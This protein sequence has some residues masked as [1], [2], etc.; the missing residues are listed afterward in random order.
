MNFTYYLN[1]LK[2]T[3]EAYCKVKNILQLHKKKFKEQDDVDS[4]KCCLWY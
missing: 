3:Y 4:F 1:G 2:T